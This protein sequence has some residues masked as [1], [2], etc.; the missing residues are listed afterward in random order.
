MQWTGVIRKLS[1]L[2]FAI[3]SAVTLCLMRG[4][5]PLQLWQHHTDK[6]NDIVFYTGIVWLFTWLL[7][8]L[9]YRFCDNQRI[10]KD[11]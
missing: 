1:L 10:T 9:E 4:I 7:Y 8:L 3:S 6:V 11:N 2:R 5:F